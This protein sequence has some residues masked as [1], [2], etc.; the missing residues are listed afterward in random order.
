MDR[1]IKLKRNRQKK[2]IEIAK[3][4]AGTWKDLSILTNSNEHYL[5]SELRREKR[6]LPESLY[7]KLCD[8][9]GYNNDHFIT[10]KLD[11]GW[12]RLKG[13]KLSPRTKP[14][15]ISIIEPSEELAE[16][17]GIMLGDGNM[18]KK[19]YAV[20]VCGDKEEDKEYLLVHVKNMFEKV[21]GIETKEYYHPSQREIILYVYSKHV[22]L[23]LEHYGLKPGNKKINK[24]AIPEWILENKNYIIPCV[25]GLMDTDGTVFA[26]NKNLKI[27][28]SSGIPPLQKSFVKAMKILGFNKKWTKSHGDVKR[29]GLYSNDDIKRFINI[30]NFNNP[31]HKRKI[32]ALVV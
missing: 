9:V 22:A 20:R 11:S 12:G 7:K 2:L 16:I 32:D 4:K 21:F 15:K 5:R 24:L 14:K 26:K 8:I 27:E 13:A 25:R 1:R 19:Q 10:D 29:Y 17:I 30:I 23:N 28:L 18:Y 31:K 6:T 3:N